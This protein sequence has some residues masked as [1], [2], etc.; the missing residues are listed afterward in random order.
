MKDFWVGGTLTGNGAPTSVRIPNLE[1][2][3]PV[4]ARMAPGR[5]FFRALLRF[6]AGTARTWDTAILR[7][8]RSTPLR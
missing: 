7:T 2:I 5:R 4:F 3:T 1:G 6:S 8:S